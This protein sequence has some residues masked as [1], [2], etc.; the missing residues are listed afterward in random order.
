M[1]GQKPKEVIIAH[2]DLWRGLGLQG[3]L[4]WIAKLRR[5]ANNSKSTQKAPCG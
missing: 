4:A 5:L 2:S 3:N 1:G